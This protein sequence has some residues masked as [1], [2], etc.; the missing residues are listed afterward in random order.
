MLS[1]SSRIIFDQIR[2]AAAFVGQGWPACDTFNRDMC[3]ENW[4]FLLQIEG[5][6]HTVVLK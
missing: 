5:W 6:R 4:C 3:L 2:A 1:V